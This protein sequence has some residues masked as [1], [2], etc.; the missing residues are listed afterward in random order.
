VAPTWRPG[1]GHLPAGAAFCGGGGQV[2][3]G[4]R[5]RRADVEILGV[6]WLDA[7]DRAGGVPTGTI[8]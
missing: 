6:A 5:R 8:G 7:S 2:V 3:A 4:E 1:P